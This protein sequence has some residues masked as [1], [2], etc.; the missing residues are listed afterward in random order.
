[1][2]WYLLRILSSCRRMFPKSL[3]KRPGLSLT[4]SMSNL[5]M[6]FARELSILLDSSSWDMFMLLRTTSEALEISSAAWAPKV[7]MVSMLSISMVL[8]RSSTSWEFTKVWFICCR[9]ATMS[10]SCTAS[11]VGSS[12]AACVVDFVKSS[13]M[14]GTSLE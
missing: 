7:T 1:M 2:V 4:S 8:T 13:P 12:G 14:S 3:P 9:S 11:S 5:D 6:I 10:Y